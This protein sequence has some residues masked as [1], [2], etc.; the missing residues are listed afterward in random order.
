ME[1]YLSE[2]KACEVVEQEEEVELEQQVNW[3]D[4]HHMQGAMTL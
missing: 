1:G 4:G 3:V 2:E